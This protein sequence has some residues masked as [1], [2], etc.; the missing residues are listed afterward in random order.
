MTEINAV[1]LRVEKTLSLVPTGNVVS[2][3]QL[4]DL[5][6]L[7][8]RARLMGKCLKSLEG[9][10]NWHRVLRAGQEQSMRLLEEGVWVKNGRVRIKDYGWQPD[11]YAILSELTY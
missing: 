7:P 5:C 10:H 2:Y 6:G 11:L 4:A 9:H 1:T 8:G 3:G